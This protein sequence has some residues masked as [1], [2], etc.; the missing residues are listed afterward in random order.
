MVILMMVIFAEFRAKFRRFARM[1]SRDS[2]AVRSRRGDGKGLSNV[3]FNLDAPASQP[4][5]FGSFRY[6]AT[7]RTCLHDDGLSWTMTR[8]A[9][10]QSTCQRSCQ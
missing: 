5:R 1:V 10:V 9:S 2:P 8:A 4:V 3:L 7:E 6:A